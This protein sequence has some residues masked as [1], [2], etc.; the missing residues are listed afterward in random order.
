MTVPQPSNQLGAVGVSPPHEQVY[1]YLIRAGHSHTVREVAEALGLSV[2]AAR[3]LLRVLEDQAL[4]T[5]VPTRP[6]GYSPSPPELAL[7][8]LVTRRSEELAQIRLF[9]KELQGEFREAAEDGSAADLIEVIVGREQSMRYFMH[10]V[11]TAKFQFDSLTK[12]PYVAIDDPTDVLHAED[13]GIRRGVRSR[14]VYESG[15]LDESL[16]LAVAEHSIAMGEEARA[17]GNVPMKLALFDGR[18]GFVPLKVDEPGLGA[19]VVH[20]SPL[21]D[22]LIALFDSIWARAVPL[23]SLRDGPPPEELNERTRQVL[24]LMSAGLKDESIARVTGMSRRTVQKHVTSAMTM[25]GARTRFQAALLARERGWVGS[26]LSHPEP[27]SA[28]SA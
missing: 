10:L 15:A 6:P 25:L 24:L 8:T 12:P 22:A 21:L 23:Q 27:G 18:I 7:E 13:A 3:D 16:T 4:V 14:S 9:A 19:L 17:V 28:V 5:R 11:H 26:A 2:R 20:P 1:R